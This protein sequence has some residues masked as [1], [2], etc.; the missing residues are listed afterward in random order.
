MSEAVLLVGGK[1]TRLRPLTV[2]TPKP[3]LPTA[4]VPFLHHVLAKAAAAGVDHV[5]LATSYR[6]EA[7]RDGLGDGSGLELGGHRLRID[8]VTEDV[9]MGTGGGI[10]NVADLLDSGPDDPVVILNGDVLSGHDLAAQ[11]AA[12]Q[13]AGADATL[14]LTE[15]EDPRAFGCVPTDGGGRVTAFLEKTPH[16]V[17][18]RIN[19]GCYVFR[20]KVIDAIPAGRPVSVERETFPGLVA[21]GSVVLGHVDAAYWLDLGTPAAF[22]QGSA[23]LVRGLAASPALPGP[24][25]ERLLLDGAA[26]A[27]DA[28]VTGG[29]TVGAGAAV[30][31]G[32]TVSGSVLLDGAVVARGAVVRRSVVG[33]AATVGED[34][35]LDGVVVGDGAV[36]GAGNELAPGARVWCDVTIPPYAIR[37]SPDEPSA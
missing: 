4:G 14:H 2:H 37:F 5:V 36:I 24:A 21:D 10:R 16:P 25:G 31:A 23:D 12:H 17:T 27:A 6:P 35:V 22:V 11:I 33:R 29:T 1:G 28:T 20:R 3:M 19:A 15:V 26:V 30:G 18:N 7:F 8:L 13:A 34:V 32:A 9:P